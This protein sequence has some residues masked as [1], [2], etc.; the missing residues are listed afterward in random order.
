MLWVWRGVSGSRHLFDFGDEWRV[1]LTLRETTPADGGTYP[2]ILQ[3][4]GAAPAQYPEVQ[5]AQD[6][7]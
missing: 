3:S 1:R 6:A 5:D 7:A 2:R 4:V